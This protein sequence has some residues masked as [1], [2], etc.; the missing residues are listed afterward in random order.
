VEDAGQVRALRRAGC[1]K[2]QGFLYGQP[3][4]AEEALA[5]TAHRRLAV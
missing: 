1:E 3:V 2:A 4:A 5:A